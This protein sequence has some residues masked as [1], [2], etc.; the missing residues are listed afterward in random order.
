VKAWLGRLRGDGRTFDYV[1]GFVTAFACAA[2]SIGEPPEAVLL[3][4]IMDD[5]DRAALPTGLGRDDLLAGLKALFDAVGAELA[6]GDFHP[7]I[8]GRYVNRLRE[9]APREQWIGGFL[10]A[11]FALQSGIEE[12]EGL[13]SLLVPFVLLSSDAQDDESLAGLS[14]KELAEARA[15]ARQAFI[16]AIHELYAYFASAEEDEP[17]E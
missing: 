10:T 6:E 1:Q 14:P 7:Y 11:F 2:P 9:D 16:G 17:G 13:S 5:P 3:L 12:D 15:T 8:G 4:A